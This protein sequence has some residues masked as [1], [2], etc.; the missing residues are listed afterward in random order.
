MT[1]KQKFVLI[2]VSILSIAAIGVSMV[3]AG[4]SDQALDVVAAAI[5][6]MAFVG[7]FW[8]VLR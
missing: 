3:I 5:P 6:S 7:F 2:L 8:L 1:S 4:R